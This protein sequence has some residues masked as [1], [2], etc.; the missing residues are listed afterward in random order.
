MRDMKRELYDDAF[1]MWDMRPSATE[2]RFG[3]AGTRYTFDTPEG[4][5][6]YWTYFRTGLFAVN[7]FNL[8]FR[9]TGTMRYRH[10]EHLTIACYDTVRGIVHAP[11]GR[12]CA[13]CACAYVGTQDGSYLGRFEQ[14]A[15]AEGVSIT[16]SPTYYRDYLQR[17]FGTS[18]DLRRDVALVDGRR[19]LPELFALLRTIKGYRGHGMAADLF[20]EGA[21][22]E[23]VSLVLDRAQRLRAEKPRL[24]ADDARV[25]D[26]ICAYI[27]DNLDKDLSSE[28]LAATGYIGQTKLK[29]LFKVAMG[30]TPAAYVTARRMGRAEELLLDGD[31][32]I[33]RIAAAVGYRSPAAFSAAFRRH[34]GLTPQERRRGSR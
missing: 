9:R 27:A 17:R 3:P 7:V 14:G 22:A 26:G 4:A 10:P 1:A 32:P 11:G 24:T 31:L 13:G 18:E 8:R 16:V 30:T 2:G 21:V 25:V 19:D 23:A 20:Y 15:L 5:G 6:D 33:E 34:T 29:R 28:T 12:P